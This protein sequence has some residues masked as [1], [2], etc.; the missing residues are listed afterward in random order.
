M[1]YSDI[2]MNLKNRKEWQKRKSDYD[3]FIK[4]EIPAYSLELCASLC[5][6]WFKKTYHKNPKF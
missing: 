6:S 2:T 5:S 1:N 3:N 4:I